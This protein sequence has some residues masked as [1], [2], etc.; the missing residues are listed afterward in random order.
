M[1]G[2]LR[3][4]ALLALVAAPARAAF[5]DLGAGARAPG[6]GNAFAATADDVYAT[7]YN[8]AGLGLLERPQLGTSYTVLFPGLK[9]ASNLS[10]SFIG[11]AQPLAEG[12]RGTLATAWNSFTL[13]S[14]Y[15]EDSL[16]LGYGRRWLEFGGRGEL[17]GGA[18]LKYLRSSFGSFPEA[19]SAVPTGGL[20][21]GGRYDPVL[22]GPRSRSAFDSDAGLLYR[23][24]KNYSAGL[25]VMHVNSPDVAFTGGASDR[26]SPAVK[27]GLGYRSL[28]SNLAVEY[29]T[30]KAPTGTRDQTFTAAAERW[31]PKLFLGD[32]GLRGGLS[33]GA[34]DY[35]Q[36][37]AG[38][39]YRTRRMSVDYALTLPVGGVAAAI[40]SHRVAL[41]FRFGRATEDEETLEMVLE[42]MKQVKA[43]ERVVLPGRDGPAG[44]SSLAFDE[45]LGQARALEA[46]ASYAAA[47][48]RFALA[49]TLAPADKALVERYARLSFVSSHFQQ[50]PDY[51]NDPAQASLHLG[52]LNYLAGDNVSAVHKVS[53]ALLIAPEPGG[54]DPG[55]K[56]IEEF[57]SRLEAAAG[58]KRTLFTGAKAPDQRS[59]VNLARAHAALEDGRYDEA[60]SLSR[61]V[62]RVE[63]DNAAAW[64]NLGTAYFALKDFDGSLEAWKRA[65]E[66][67]KSPRLRAAIKDTLRKVSRAREKQ[68]A[69]R[70]RRAAP[71]LPDRPALTPQEAQALYNKAVDQYVRR[72]FAAAKELLEK[73]LAADPGNE[74]AQK[75]LRRVK[76]EMP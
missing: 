41:T 36:L 2:A 57:L 40:S 15:R 50:L 13:N 58:I 69:V 55:R 63:P 12:R 3:A 49:L 43:G 45:A 27:L 70:A 73:I 32:I 30:Q 76:E 54:P 26:L 17:Y 75:A 48:E 5:E 31:F 39:S 65:Y 10:A 42:A 53:S 52:I 64:E 29:G 21:G 7:Y 66:L 4:A 35:K 19:G 8:P 72:E 23:L 44:G 74:P 24:G 16:Y 28:I 33:V 18:N 20:V 56:E 14:L 22:S 59:T 71:P 51:Q 47:L 67:E 25:G 68:P 11:Y 1:R 61:E 38:L 34:R 60:V 9:D 37:S 6:M 62:L 46:R